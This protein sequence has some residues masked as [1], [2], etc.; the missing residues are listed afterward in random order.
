MKIYLSGPITGTK[1]ARERFER[2]GEEIRRQNYEPA[3]PE[4]ELR[5]YA[6]KHSYDEIMEE[7]YK[8]LDSCDGIYM[9]TGWE[10]SRGALLE[11]E[12]AKANAIPVRYQDIMPRMPPE[13]TRRDVLAD[14]FCSCAGYFT[15]KYQKGSYR[16]ARDAYNAASIIYV[17]GLG[18]KLFT[19]EDGKRF[20]GQAKE[21]DYEPGIFN[22]DQVRRCSEHIRAAQREENEAA[23]QRLLAHRK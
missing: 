20:F 12:Y 6:K 23:I 1:D 9:M 8:L 17:M 22:T 11:W 19:E 18:E 15:E 4:A 14:V 21:D 5:E 7:C 10:H 16:S 13:K 2:A 3:N